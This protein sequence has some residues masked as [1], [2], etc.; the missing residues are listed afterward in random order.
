MSFI[1]QSMPTKECVA[2]LIELYKENVTLSCI[3]SD[4]PRVV[5]TILEYHVVPCTG[6]GLLP[7]F[8]PYEINLNLKSEIRLWADIVRNCNTF[9]VIILLCGND[10]PLRGCQWQTSSPTHVPYGHRH[11]SRMGH[12]FLFM[13]ESK[14]DPPPPQSIFCLIFTN[15][16]LFCF[17]V[18]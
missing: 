12:R 13:D 15:G 11:M 14:K 2:V 9:F 3:G 4:L 6:I 16:T 17:S 18:L 7:T 1:G 10:D 8:Q 5:V